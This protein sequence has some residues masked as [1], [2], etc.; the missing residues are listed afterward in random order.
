[1]LLTRIL[2][3]AT[4]HF[5]LAYAAA[6]IANGWDLD[7]V[8]LNPVSRSAAGLY[9]VLMLPH[10]AFIHSLPAAWL[11]RFQAFLLL[12]VLA[13]SLLWGLA[14]MIV[15]RL[16]QKAWRRTPCTSVSA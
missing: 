16:V 8:Y 4:A 7:H 2:G 3:F 13:N 15:V 12:P 9:A 14:L 6:F 11:E 5:A 1:M 10:S